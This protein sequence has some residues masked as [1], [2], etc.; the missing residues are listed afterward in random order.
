MIKILTLTKHPTKMG[1]PMMFN[2]IWIKRMQAPLQRYPKRRRKLLNVNI[3]CQF[4]PLGVRKLK[5]R[6]KI[7]R[8]CLS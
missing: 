2:S 3:F 8:V 1:I 7:R 4:K 6:P 5:L